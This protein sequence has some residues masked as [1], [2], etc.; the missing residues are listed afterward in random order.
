L[1]EKLKD[2]S[3]VYHPSA[4]AK[5]V[6]SV[7]ASTL[8]VATGVLLGAVQVPKDSAVAVRHSKNFCDSSEYVA[9]FSV[10]AILNWIS[11]LLWQASLQ[12]KRYRPFIVEG[13][14]DFKLRK[15]RSQ[16]NMYFI[17]HWCIVKK[18]WK[19]IEK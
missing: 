5:K 4:L 14:N 1:P 13:A 8:D 3:L 9:V 15:E 7:L 11:G 18:F 16:V 6:S 12:L 10:G 17:V 19:R 2:V